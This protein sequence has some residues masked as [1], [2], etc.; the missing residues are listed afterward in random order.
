MNTKLNGE[1]DVSNHGPIHWEWIDEWAYQSFLHEWILQVNECV[2]G[3]LDV[4][5]DTAMCGYIKDL[6]FELMNYCIN[7]KNAG[8]YVNLD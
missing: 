8:M 6:T 3:Y 1:L 5:I 4:C 2:P 7:P